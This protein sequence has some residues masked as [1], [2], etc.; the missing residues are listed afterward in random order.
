MRV[1]CD[2]SRFARIRVTVPPPGHKTHPGR[3][4]SQEKHL[5][6]SGIIAATVAASLSVTAIAQAIDVNQ[7]IIVKT[8]GKKGKV[9][10][11]TTIKLDVTT[12]TSAKDEKKN[13]TFATRSAVI[14]FDKNLRF[15]AKK[16]PTCTEQTVVNA[17]ATCPVG[18]F[19]GSGFAKAIIG[20]GQI[21]ANPTIKAYNAKG[22]KIIL[23]LLKAE[24]EVDSSGV[25]TGT[26]KTDTGKYANRLVV[27]IPEKLQTQFG[28]KIT[29]TTFNTVIKAQKV[30]KRGY[31]ESIGCPKNGNYNFG[32]DF[33]FDDGSTAKVTARSKC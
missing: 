2:T 12:K 20:E 25:L 23:R 6:K 5:R 13:G 1:L 4:H 26:L 30:K 9:A 33:V 19:V 18:S 32:G 31:V 3:P 27:P 16:F 28:L 10:K 22:G 29:L 8:T 21:P 11:P 7:S 17:P 24:N 14:H 15:N